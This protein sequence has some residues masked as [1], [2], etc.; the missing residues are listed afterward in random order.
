MLKMQIGFVLRDLR[1]RVRLTHEDVAKLTASPGEGEAAPKRIGGVTKSS[2][3]RYEAGQAVPKVPVLRRILRVL[4]VNEKSP[5]VVWGQTFTLED[6]EAMAFQAAKRGWWQSEFGDVSVPNWLS[7]YFGLEPEASRLR[8]FHQV[9]PGLFQTEGYATALVRMDIKDPSE[10][11][12]LVDIRKARQ[13]IFARADPPDIH[14][15]LEEGAIQRLAESEGISPGHRHEQIL[16]LVERAALPN[17]T[18]QI[19]PYRAGMHAARVASSFVIMSFG[20]RLPEIV[21]SE[22]YGPASSLIEGT[23]QPARYTRA[24]RD[25]VK[26]ALDPD[27]S[28]AMLRAAARRIPKAR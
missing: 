11:R 18:L 9:I 23:D 21:C 25:L 5:A 7:T 2:I 4:G 10:I 20:D 24:F 15:V 3:S 26:N 8:I 6:L 12:N 19:L 14:V 17:V 13:R 22:A 16:R 27:E 1:E 28:V